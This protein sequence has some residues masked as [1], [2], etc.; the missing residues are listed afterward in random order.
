M[1]RTLLAAR[2]LAIAW[3]ISVPTVG[4]GPVDSVPVD[5][6]P[7]DS[8]PVDSVPVDPFAEPFVDSPVVATDSALVGAPDPVV[9]S[10]G[11]AATLCPESAVSP[12]QPATATTGIRAA[13]T[14]SRARRRTA[15][16]PPAR[17]MGRLPAVVPVA[18]KPALPS[19]SRNGH[20]RVTVCRIERRIE[21]HL[22][23]L[24][25]MADPIGE[26]VSRHQAIREINGEINRYN[27]A[28]EHALLRYYYLIVTREAMGMRR[29]QWVEKHYAVPP[30]RRHLQDF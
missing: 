20:P 11:D 23:R 2:A 9:A 12:E 6:V 14:N 29:H 15:C 28:R 27:R 3:V 22:I 4:V 25:E 18:A 26:S 8:V 19:K 10:P 16:T 30:R 7:V 13:T 17:S 1:T 21:T 5:S 24:E